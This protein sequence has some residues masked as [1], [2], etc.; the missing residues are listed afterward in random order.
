MKYVKQLLLILIISLL[1]ELCNFILPLPVP[2]SIYGMV[3]L[4]VGLCTGFI[5]LTYVR[6]TGLYLIAIMP[7][8]FIPAGVGLLTSWGVLRPFLL[9]VSV[10]MVSAL[11]LVMI[12]SGHFTQW[13]IRMTNRKE[14]KK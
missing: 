12:I 6:E 4:F 14:Q 9:P 2:A 13:I 5:K 3:I 11:V 8:M 10:I 1:G 7:V